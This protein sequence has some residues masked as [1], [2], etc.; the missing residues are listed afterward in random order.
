MFKDGSTACW[1]QKCSFCLVFKLVHM[2]RCY[3]VRLV[4]YYNIIAIRLYTY[5][6]VISMEQSYSQLAAYVDAP[7]SI[8]LIY[9]ACN[10][11]PEFK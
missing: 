11:G 2:Q 6:L 3:Y 1:T 7:T 4:Y 8:H 10:V 9:S 5:I